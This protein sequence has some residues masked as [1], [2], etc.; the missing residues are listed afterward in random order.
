MAEILHHTSEHKEQRC[1]ISATSA[2][3]QD[4]LLPRPTELS[5]QTNTQMSVSKCQQNVM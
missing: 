4:Q 1:H 2:A 3:P 5:E